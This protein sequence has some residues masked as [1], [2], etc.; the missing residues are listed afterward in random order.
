MLQLLEHFDKGAASLALLVGVLFTLAQTAKI[1]L[2][3]AQTGEVPRIL[4]LPEGMWQKAGRAL[5][6]ALWLTFA[7]VLYYFAKIVYV[8]APGTARGWV[9]LGVL[10][11]GI[12]ATGILGI[13]PLPFDKPGPPRWLVVTA[14]I[15][16]FY[17]LGAMV[18]YTVYS[19][20]QRSTEIKNSCVLRLE[21]GTLAGAVA[22]SDVRCV[23]YWMQEDIP[24]SAAF[25]GEQ[26]L[27]YVAA[28]GSDV[29]IL[30]LLLDSGQFNPNIPTAD[31]D[32]PLHAAVRNGR[33]DMVCRLIA[34]GA[35]SHVPNHNFITPLDLARDLSEQDLVALIEGETCLPAE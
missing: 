10:I 3:L 34:H 11:L 35:L 18:V 9:V 2:S 7:A 15:G 26:P 25:A 19:F 33:P 29:R 4:K 27:L 5:G 24:A 22:H 21:G 17:V 32:T 23:D 1:L 20:G 28:G 16:V 31:G 6:C 8:W 14:L 12:V 30:T 13:K